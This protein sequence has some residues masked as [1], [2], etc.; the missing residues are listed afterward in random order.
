MYVISNVDSIVTP[1]GGAVGGSWS[2]VVGVSPSFTV[3]VTVSTVS[4]I[5][6]L[7]P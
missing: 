3:I 2:I 5:A 6:T 1:V 4:D 7:P